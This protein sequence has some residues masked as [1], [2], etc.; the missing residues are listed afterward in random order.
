METLW[1][2]LVAALFIGFA[3]LDGFDI[4]LGS[5]YLLITKSEAERSQVRAAIGPIWGGNEVW[6]VAGAG[7]L[8]FAFPSA[9]ATIFSKFYLGL[10]LLL[11]FLILRG[12]SIELR[13]QLENP[14][15]HSFWDTVFNLAS[16]ALAG[17]WGIMLGNLLRGVALHTQ[18]DPTIPLWT[19]FLPGTDPGLLDWYTVLVAGFAFLVFAVQGA[20]FLAWKTGGALSQRAKQWAARGVW[21]LIP[22]LALVVGLTLWVRP[23]LLDNFTRQPARFVFPLAAV[24]ALIGLVVFM[25]RGQT[26][27][28]FLASSVLIVLL[29]ATAMNAMFPNFLV[30]SMG[31]SDLTIYNSMANARNLQLGLVWF[32]IGFVLLLGYVAFMY[33]S[34]WGKV[35]QGE[36][37]E[38]Y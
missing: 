26:G 22:S 24:L 5:I 13:T 3:V 20:N 36:G 29:S 30:D 16:L 15:W 34:F 32:G 28:T 7:T 19:N 1:Y 33:H 8:F 17:L 38:A 6:L 2:A 10:F 35:S 31:G 9:Y 11:W 4:G 21:L 25:R 14:L 23:G 18:G 27:R 12:L 37:S